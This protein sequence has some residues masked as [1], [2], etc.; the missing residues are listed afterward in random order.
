[1]KKNLK[2]K[3]PLVKTNTP[4]EVKKLL[5]GEYLWAIPQT[6]FMHSFSI[7]YVISFF[8]T[9]KMEFFIQ[10]LDIFQSKK[11]QEFILH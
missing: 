4:I 2:S 7:Q 8:K 9:H 3:K 1:M 10:E 5:T 6:G 11:Y